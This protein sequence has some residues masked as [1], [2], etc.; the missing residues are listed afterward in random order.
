MRRPKQRPRMTAQA[1]R[2]IADKLVVRERGGVP[3]SDGARYEGAPNAAWTFSYRRETVPG[4]VTDPSHLL[5]VVE[6]EMK[7]ASFFLTMGGAL[8]ARDAPVSLTIA[9][10]QAAMI[11]RAVRRASSLRSLALSAA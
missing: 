11:A 10:V 2:A 3:P 8:R 1:A 7:K 9:A 6:V 4:E 5:V